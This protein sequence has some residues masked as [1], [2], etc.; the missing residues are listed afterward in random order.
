MV[1]TCVRAF[2]IDAG[3]RVFKHEG[4]CAHLHG[5]TY[6]IEVHARGQLDELGRV[7]DFSVLKER[8][9]TWLDINWD[10]GFVLNINDGAVHSAL[11]ALGSKFYLLPYNPTAENMAKYLLVHVCPEALNNTGIEVFKV[12]VHE[13]PNCYAEATL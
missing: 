12:V 8:I 13:T 10:H 4:K 3:H 9:G 5:H 11:M 7:I 6:R 2:T 1:Q